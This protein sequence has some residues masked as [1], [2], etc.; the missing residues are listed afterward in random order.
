MKEVKAYIRANMADG[1]VD[2]LEQLDE[3][4]AVAVVSLR[5]FGHRHSDGQM[6]A[7]EMV[8][9]EM[10]VMESAVG[11][12]VDCI[13]QHARTGAGH[14]GDGKVF[15]SDLA[16]AVRIE[17]GKRGEEALRHVHD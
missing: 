7:V 13:L 6:Q 12:V 3:V 15:V 14:P 9:L 1:V 4:P 2:A 16:Q 5:E 11:V 10:D 8:K 17:D